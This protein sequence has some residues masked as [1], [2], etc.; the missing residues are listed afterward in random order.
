MDRGVTPAKQ[1]T[2]PTWGSLPPC[3]QALKYL[4][5]IR[6]IWK[7]IS[8]IFQF[9]VVVLLAGTNNHHSSADQLVEGIETIVWS[10]SSKLPAAKIIVLVR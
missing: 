5:E 2:S 10:I 6:I 3:K 7:F 8:I 1:V 9:K 4:C